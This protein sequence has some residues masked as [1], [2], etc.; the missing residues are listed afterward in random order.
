MNLFI[1]KYILKLHNYYYSIKFNLII[2]Y[3]VINYKIKFQI[4]LSKLV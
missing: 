2:L 1:N 4:K 3:T